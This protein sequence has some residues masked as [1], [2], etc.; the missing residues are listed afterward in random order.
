MRTIADLRKENNRTSDEYHDT[1]KFIEKFKK[2]FFEDIRSLFIESFQ[3][4]I[5]PDWEILGERGFLDIKHSK[6]P[7]CDFRIIIENDVNRLSSKEDY[8]SHFSIK[9]N[10]DLF[11][12]VDDVEYLNLLSNLSQILLTQSEKIIFDFN[13]YYKRYFKRYNQLVKDL[14]KLKEAHE[15]AVEKYNE[16]LNG[17]ILNYLLEN[18]TIEFNKVPK[19][20]EGQVNTYPIFETHKIKTV[21][22][23]NYSSSPFVLS[24]EF[25]DKKGK[26]IYK[27]TL[28]DKKLFSFQ[29]PNTKSSYIMQYYALIKGLKV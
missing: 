1:R 4:H 13:T 11:T 29:A 27:E 24:L 19:D 15:K 20:W 8:F 6:L 2:E 14:P 18:K 9:I 5:P 17:K 7:N 10:R 22:L 23:K 28:Y 3:D 21:N 25:C 16:Y 26:V 12:T